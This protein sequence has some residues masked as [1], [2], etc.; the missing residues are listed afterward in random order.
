MRSRRFLMT[1]AAVS[2][3][4]GCGKP[5]APSAPTKTATAPD[6]NPPAVVQEEPVGAGDQSMRYLLTNKQGMKVELINL[7]AAVTSVDVPDRDGNSA[8]VTLGFAELDAYDKNAPYFGV[9]CGRYANRIA[10]AKFSLDGLDYTLV[11]NNGEN[12]LHGGKVGYGRRIWSAQKLTPQ[13]GARAVRFTYESPDGE[14]GYPGT[15]KA[16]VT[17]TLTD[18]NELKIEYTAQSDKPTVVNLTNHAYWNLAGAGSGTIDE[19]L[20]TVHADRYLPVDDGLIPTGE[21]ESVEGTPF[22]FRTP[23]AVGARYEEAGGGYD[24]CYVVNPPASPSKAGKPLVP[25][26]RVSDPKSGRVMEVLTTEPG[27]QLYTGNFLEG[28]PETGGFPKH[29]GLCLEC[30]H[31]PDSPNRPEFPSTVL[32]PGEVY[33]QTTI[34]RFSVEK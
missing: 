17:Y 3:A 9:I 13:A 2:L 6:P 28:T 29:A 8:N 15:L 4:A 1:L 23:T 5:P 10:K 11:A 19:H 33:T 18:D 12:H 22:D 20:L 16:I 25:A 27:V 7:G 26:A 14:E 24:L 21:L 31:Y 32:K 30:Q 34:Y